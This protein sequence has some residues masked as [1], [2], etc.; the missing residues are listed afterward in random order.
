VNVVVGAGLCATGFLLWIVWIVANRASLRHRRHLRAA[1]PPTM[2]LGPEP[3]AVVNVLLHEAET[4]GDAVAATIL[5]LAAR[6]FLDI[7]QLSPSKH[8][9]VPRPKDRGGLAPYEVQVLGVIDRAAA[10]GRE[11]TV[12]AIS[13]A[14]GR[15]SA[16]AWFAF[17]AAV[18]ADARRRGLVDTRSLSK[19]LW[20]LLMLTALTCAGVVIIQPLAYL[21][22]VPIFV[23]FDIGGIVAVAIGNSVVFTDAGQRAGA[24]WLGVKGFILDAG[25]LHDLP[26]G[27]VAVWDRYLAYGA[28]MGVSGVAVHSLV[29]E[30]RTT[31][32]LSDLRNVAGEVRRASRARHAAPTDWAPRGS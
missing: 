4:T 28:A 22:A 19:G 5:D 17:A 26:A 13:E 9:V 16:M 23:V 11:A 20:P 21:A 14:L 2:E 10:G 31:L 7:V 29:E 15:D 1:D 25:S 30:L 27:A 24:R 8:L 3:P 18:T 6:R 12:P 32:S